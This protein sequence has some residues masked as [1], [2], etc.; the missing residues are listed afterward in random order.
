MFFFLLDLFFNYLKLI[1]LL[2]FL[3]LFSFFFLGWIVRA[4]F[5]FFHFFKE[6]LFHFLSEQFIVQLQRIIFMELLTHDPQKRCNIFFQKFRESQSERYWRWIPV[7]TRIQNFLILVKVT[8]SSGKYLFIPVTNFIKSPR[9]SKLNFCI[10]LF[11]LLFIS[12]ELLKHCH[13]RLTFFVKNREVH[14]R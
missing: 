14:L 11:L 4:I 8:F 6:L 5:Q 10:N 2:V 1:L 7:F 3:F 9:E 12:L 13:I